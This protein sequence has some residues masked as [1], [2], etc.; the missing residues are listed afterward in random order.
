MDLFET[1]LPRRFEA[2]V[3]LQLRQKRTIAIALA[4]APL[5]FEFSSSR[6]LATRLFHLARFPTH[7]LGKALSKS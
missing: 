5:L 2:A 1:R 3:G 7:K 6:S 4:R